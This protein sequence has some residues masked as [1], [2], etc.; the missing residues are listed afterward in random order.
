M[1]T[2]SS[3]DNVAFLIFAIKFPLGF[4]HFVLSL[5]RKTIKHLPV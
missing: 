4:L 3:I 1:Y 2:Q 5:D